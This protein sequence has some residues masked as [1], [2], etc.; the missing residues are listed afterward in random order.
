MQRPCY[1]PRLDNAVAFALDQ[2]RFKVR[3]GTSVP[4][5]TH[6][7]AVMTLV[8]EYGGDEDQ[9]MGAVLHDYLEDIPG[10][11]ADLLRLRFGDRVARFVVALSD[12]TTLPKPPWRERKELYLEHLAEE[13][14]DL[15][16]ISCSDK[17]HN[18]MCIRRDYQ[19]VGDA[20]WGRFSGG[21]EGT[22]WYYR[23]V[24]MALGQ[25]WQ[26]PLLN[27]LRAEVFQLEQ[28]TM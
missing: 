8:G 14:P 1:S 28:E 19:A 21:K 23:A 10:A 26:H 17:L 25:D 12:S 27:R 16:L 7:L 22:L 15:K 6:L 20:V 13:A 5:V 18:C 4:Y 2:F 24:C 3:K 9:M 11:S